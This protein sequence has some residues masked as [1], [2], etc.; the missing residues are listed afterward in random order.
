MARQSPP[1]RN[2]RGVDAHGGPVIDPTEN[3]KALSEAATKRQ[4]DLRQSNNELYDAKFAT[5]CARVRGL[6]KA[7]K[8][9]ASHTAAIIVLQMERLDK[10]RQVDVLNASA[11]AERVAEAVRTLATT[12]SSDREANRALVASSASGLASQLSSL[13]GES[14]K[15]LAAVESSLSEGRGKQQVEDP[16]MR[17]LTLA[18]GELVRAQAAHAGKGQGSGD[19]AKWIALAISAIVGLIAI[20][21]FVFTNRQSAAPPVAA[22]PQIIVVPAGAPIPSAVQTGPPTQVTR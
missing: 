3:V 8:R 16:Q 15:R 19:M 4:D 1:P 13:F 11:A 5:V 7:N 12:T 18:V 17:A 14:N 9:E 6:E 22:A 20:G 21:A 10:I 2:G